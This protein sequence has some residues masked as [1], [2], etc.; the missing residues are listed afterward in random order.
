MD[1]CRRPTLL[2]RISCRLAAAVVGLLVL[3]L[4]GCSA[5]PGIGSAFGKTL[6]AV[7]LKDEAAP[8]ELS[9][10]LQAATNLNAGS[11]GRPASLVVRVYQLRST[12]RFSDAPFAAF[13]DEQRESD[14]LGPDLL[15][16]TEILLAPGQ[17]HSV[18]EP[19]AAGATHVGVVALFREPAA[20]RWRLAF[21]VGRAP[22]QGIA[23]GMHAC[24]MTTPGPALVT[25]LATGSHTLAGNQCGTDG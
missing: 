15:S 1:G 24:A 2:P 10:Q 17:R 16:V 3:A 4:A 13:L 20:T 11:D 21:D 22:P 19:L 25:A 23:V 12:A 14:I 6:Q 5:K 7:G 8:T 9:L 18:L